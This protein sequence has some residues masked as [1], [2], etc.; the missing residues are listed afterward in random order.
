MAEQCTKVWL[1]IKPFLVLIS[2][3][4]F[5]LILIDWIMKTYFFDFSAP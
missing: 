5:K 2:T 1:T 3:Y 4:G